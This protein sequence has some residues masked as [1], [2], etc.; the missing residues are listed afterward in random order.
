MRLFGNIFSEELL[1]LIMLS[2]IP[3]LLPLPFMAIAIFT[4][5][6]QAYVFVLLTCIYLAG[7]IEEE[8]E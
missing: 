7:A 5:V 3:Y 6:I 4:A 8:Q 2:I 1:I